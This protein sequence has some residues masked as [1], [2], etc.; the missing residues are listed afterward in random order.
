MQ[1]ISS[2]DNLHKM[3]K[4]IFWEKSLLNLLREYNVVMMVKVQWFFFF[5][6]ENKISFNINI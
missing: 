4:P 5:F 2:G 6:W 1:I 3:S